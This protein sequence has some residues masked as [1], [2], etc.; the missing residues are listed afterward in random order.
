MGPVRVI[1]FDFNADEV[2]DR[3]DLTLVRQLVG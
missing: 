3:I 1:M 2:V